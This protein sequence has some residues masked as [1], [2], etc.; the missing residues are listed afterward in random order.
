MKRLSN[1]II[2]ASDGVAKGIYPNSI[3]IVKGQSRIM[4]FRDGADYAQLW[5][6]KN[7]S[8]G[9]FSQVGYALKKNTLPAI[10]LLRFF[11]FLQLVIYALSSVVY[12][13]RYQRELKK[14]E[15]HLLFE[16]DQFQNN[17]SRWVICIF[18]SM[19]ISEILFQS[20]VKSTRRSRIGK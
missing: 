6:Y 17:E 11:G 16:I 4:S 19:W 5:N 20:D 7:G 3:L 18:E 15:E 1:R 2:E 14:R 10:F 9:I 12:N 8:Q 13:C